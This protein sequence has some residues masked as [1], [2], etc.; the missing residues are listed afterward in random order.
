M[1]KELYSQYSLEDFDVFDCLKISKGIYLLLLFV[2]RGYIVWIMSVTNMNDRVG[3]IQ[4][5]YPV[6]A[7]FY[8]SLLSGLVGIFV[9]LVLSLRRPDAAP[10][11]RFCWRHCRTLLVITLIFD[12]IVSVL[13]ELYLQ[14]FSIS[15]IC[16]QTLLVIAF[17]AFCFN[18]K[19][20]N[21]NLREFPEKLPEK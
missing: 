12:L 16:A 5:V 10:W 17:V 15:W 3:I 13:G 9:V 18:S 4:W 1:T 7:L 21:I 20:F 11:V 2:L 6:P 19:R 14:M 8:L